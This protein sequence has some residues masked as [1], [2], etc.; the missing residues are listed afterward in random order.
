MSDVKKTLEER[1]TRYGE[2]HEQAWY[3]QG[4]K[5]IL[6]TSPKWIEMED[7]QR[8]ALDMIANKIARILNGDPNY[9]DSWIDIA[10]YATL[11]ANRLEQLE[12]SKRREKATEEANR[13]VDEYIQERRE[14]T[15]SEGWFAP[16]WLREGESP[17][18][19]LPGVSV[20]VPSEILAVHPQ[21]PE[22]EVDEMA[23][24]V[25]RPIYF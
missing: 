6:Q 8:E 3:A 4:I 7:E 1:G 19:P 24:E 25:F 10:G 22:S 11:I 16:Q 21:W 17:N 13:K 12:E 5:A 9:A 20:L 14:Q 23:S 15:L 2:F 18:A